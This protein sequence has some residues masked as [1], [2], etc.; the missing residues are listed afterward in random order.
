VTGDPDFVRWVSRIR[1][2]R[3]YTGERATR[4]LRMTPQRANQARMDAIYAQHFNAVAAYCMRR[5]PGEAAN[6]AI[7][8]TFLVTWRKLDQVPHAHGTLPWLYRV[9]GNVIAHQRRSFAR[10]SRL[11]RKLGSVA[12]EPIAGP[13]LQVLDH[14]ANQE[15]LEALAGLG[16]ADREIIRLRTWEELTALQIAEVLQ[17]SPAAAR[18]RISRA[19]ARLKRSLESQ[20]SIVVEGGRP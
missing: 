18:K 11:R 13:E 16:D 8:E 15:V 3:E 14:A 5:L 12:P 1:F 20:D 19:L 2:I 9:A 6:D 7:A 17:I 4:E 10:R